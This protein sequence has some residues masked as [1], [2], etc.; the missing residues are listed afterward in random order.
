MVNTAE[1]V[2][3]KGIRADVDGHTVAVGSADLLDQ[4]LDKAR[5]LELN[6]AGKTAMYVR[7][8]RANAEAGGGSTGPIPAQT[9]GWG[10]RMNIPRL[11]SLVRSMAMVMRARCT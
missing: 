9:E 10:Q 2:A 1:P 7:V 4:A 5:I 11:W 6:A 3:G 8:G